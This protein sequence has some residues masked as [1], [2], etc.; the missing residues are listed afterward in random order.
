M[1]IFVHAY[2]YTQGWGTPTASQHKI[3]DS[4]YLTNFSCAPD[5]IRT[6]VLWILSLL[7]LTGPQVEGVAQ[8]CMEMLVEAG[9]Y[10]SA[11]RIVRLLLDR[12]N[13]R[14]LRDL[15]VPGVR[16]PFHISCI[17]EHE[18]LLSK[19]SFTARSDQN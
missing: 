3:F 5:G 4:E 19:V 13:V 18:R 17:N 6:S 1:I 10:V 11:D 16:F 14:D 8:D 2:T 9:D 7:I 12:Y 15:Q